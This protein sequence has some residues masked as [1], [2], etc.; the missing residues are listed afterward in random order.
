MDAIF[1]S[2]TKYTHVALSTKAS[3][4]LRFAVLSLRFGSGS[5]LAVHHCKARRLVAFSA[6]DPKRSLEAGV[7]GKAKLIE[8]I[9]QRLQL[10]FIFPPALH[11]GLVDRS[12]HLLRA[13]S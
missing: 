13:G 6:D 10:L 11:R 7:H 9:G 3:K 4:S 1:R 5:I 12:A 2:R 8:C